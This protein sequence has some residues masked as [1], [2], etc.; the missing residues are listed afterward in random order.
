LTS[1]L[2][3]HPP[4]SPP[5]H[6]SPPDAPRFPGGT[7]PHL[8]PA[9]GPPP[10]P[11]HLDALAVVALV[12][13]AIGLLAGLLNFFGT[14]LAMCCAVCA[15]G[16]TVLGVLSLLASVV[17]AV[18][19]FASH[20]RIVARPEALSGDTLAKIAV[21]VGILGALAAAVSTLL[22]MLGIAVNLG[23]KAV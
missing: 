2:G 4:A 22:P 8:A 12:F 6:G 1:P 5:A 9:G 19:G 20:R 11:T 21:A 10:P 14:T 15:L 13:S 23:L 16:T 3:P 18:L 17:G 7:G